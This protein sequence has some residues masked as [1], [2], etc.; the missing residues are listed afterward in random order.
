MDKHL[1]A[2]IDTHREGWSHDEW[3]ALLNDLR[4]EGV[5]VSDSEAIGVQLERR[6]RARVRADL[7]IRGLGEKRIGAI[8]DR[9]GTLWAVRHAAADDV[10]EIR[11]IPAS[12][13]EKVVAAF[14]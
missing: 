14:R 2:F 3:L 13:A 7:E 9:F 10:S 12:L 5:D 4:H 6:R 1:D 11:T 8:V